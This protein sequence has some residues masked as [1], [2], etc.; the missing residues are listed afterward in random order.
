MPWPVDDNAAE[1]GGTAS[2]GVARFPRDGENFDLLLSHAE[3]AMYRAKTTGGGQHALFK[4]SLLEPLGD[5]GSDLARALDRGELRLY[6]QPVVD[7]ASGQ[8]VGAEALLRW[9]HPRDG[10]LAPSRFI[11]RA[12]ACG[13]L[14]ALELAALDQA[15]AQVS[16]WKQMGLRTGRVSLNVSAREFHHAEWSEELA[17][18]MRRHHVAQGELAVE[19]TEGALMDDAEATRTRVEALR[20]LG[21]SLVIDDFGSGLISLAR[22]GELRP[23]MVKLDQAFVQGLPDDAAA[24]DMVSGKIGRAHV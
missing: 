6:F 12:E 15:C 13:Q 14:H 22:L 8:A 10:L 4:P 18:A 17:R 16:Q 9:Q 19:L 11:G 3:Q 24:R 7:T 21:V 1:G 23:A 20:Q 5:G 2:I